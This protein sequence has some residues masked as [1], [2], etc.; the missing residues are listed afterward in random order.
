MKEIDFLPDWYRNGAKRQINLRRQYMAVG[1]VFAIILVWNFTTGYSVSKAS[2]ELASMTEKH[3]SMG[4][5]IQNFNCVKAQMA[6]LEEKTKILERI[7]S[8]INV[9]NVLA[10]LSFLIDKKIVIGKV[11]FK[12]DRFTD[13]SAGNRGARS[14]VR[15][16]R[17]DSGSKESP[18]LGNVR[19]QVA[20]SGVAVESGAVPELILRLEESP[21]F[22]QVALSFSRNK[23]KAMSKSEVRGKEYSLTEFEINCYLANYQ[24]EGAGTI[25]NTRNNRS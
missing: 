21:Y 2:A 6:E 1:G 24:I 22:C 18:F 19:F 8:Q 23:K 7:D 15:S 17:G 20:I 16:A 25:K 12:A 11:E 9:A 13:G 5:D 4:N 3:L 10:E 14:T